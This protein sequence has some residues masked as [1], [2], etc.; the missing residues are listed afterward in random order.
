MKQ[1]TIKDLSLVN[2]KGHRNLTVKFEHETVISGDN[3]TGKS[4]VMDAFLWLMFG[5]DQFD[6]SDYEIIPIVE[7]TRFDKVDPE[8]TATIQVDRKSYTL[9][10][11]MH[12]KW[13]RK[14]GTETEVFDGCEN[15]YFI[16]E[17]PK[18][19]SE[20]KAL[21]AMI[22]E[23]GLFK[24]IT[25]PSNFLNLPWEKQREF[26]FQVSGTITDEQIAAENPKFK[27]LLDALTGKSMKDFKTQIS[28]QK[29][30]LKDELEKVQPKIDQTTRLMPT[31]KDWDS[32]QND[33]KEVNKEISDID[34]MMSDRSAAIRGQYDEIQRKQKLINDL[35]TK[36][37]EVVYN[38]QAANRQS[39]YDQ[40]QAQG[41]YLKKVKE[42]QQALEDAGTEHGKRLAVI[43]QKRDTVKVKNVQIEN[44]RQ[45][46]E[47]EN[48]KEYKAV[49]GCL[50]CPVYG[51]ICTDESAKANHLANE[52]AAKLAF[53]TAKNAKLDEIDHRGSTLTLE[54]L[55]LNSEI[56]NLVSKNIEKNIK[57]GD[58][59]KQLS[60]LKSKVPATVEPGIVIP[61]ELPE[62]QDLQAQIDRIN[63]MIEEVKP[64]DNSDLLPKKSELLAKR[65]LINNQL[66]ERSTIASFKA[67]IE[68]LGK[69]GKE[70]AQ[71]IADLE[72]YE[73][74]M[75][76]FTRAKIQE[77]ENRINGLF[78]VV[79]WKLLDKTNEGNEFECCIATNLSGVPIKA[80]NTAE[81]IN[82]GLDI[83]R[84]LSTFYNVQAPIFCDGSESVNRYIETGA[85]MVFLK[86]TKEKVLTIA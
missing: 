52:Q 31:V 30:K 68:S 34:T 28:A 62:W 76:D 56:D 83:I 49:E 39:A 6:R 43:N 69:Q 64:V 20:Y 4:T 36:Q 77:C 9:K 48:A 5:K 86:V 58:L 3:A 15:L 72:K 26:L 44:L 80:T 33:L 42:A 11:V 29:K 35:K 61:A 79:K 8:V 63:S 47:S 10:K 71:Q 78:Q 16:D 2:F 24:M 57:V 81:K 41:D 22:V 70:Y 65:D 84:T 55:E 37:S 18:K 45:E 73:F 67:E 38:R 54:V 74:L 75:S 82:A 7:G 13:V 40:N 66:S 23:E 51:N 17:V 85:Q 60:E 1:V 32:L 46:W 25:N 53:I 19:A 59:T 14:R 21:I 50:I 27:V 12:Q